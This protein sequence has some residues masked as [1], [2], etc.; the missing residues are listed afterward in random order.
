MTTQELQ[1]D[2]FH[3]RAREGSADLLTDFAA[4]CR[5]ITLLVAAC[6]ARGTLPPMVG[7]DSGP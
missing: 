2:P 3:A 6:G 1:S 5:K 7:L 4:N